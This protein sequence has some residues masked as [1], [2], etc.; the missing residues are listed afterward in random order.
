V[1]TKNT[2]QSGS[3]RDFVKKYFFSSVPFGI[4]AKNTFSAWFLLEFHQKT[5]FQPGSYR[6]FGKKHF[7]KLFPSEPGQKSFL[8]VPHGTQP[9]SFLP[10][11]YE[12]PHTFIKT[13]KKSKY[14]I[15]DTCSSFILDSIITN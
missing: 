9:I 15:G 5:L 2:F 11:P 1:S 10:V 3:Y 6:N 8:S 4:S 14:L 12:T 7:F 13:N